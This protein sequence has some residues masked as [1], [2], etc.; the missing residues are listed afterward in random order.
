MSDR[1]VIIIGAGLAGLA[2]GVYAQ[3]AG[4]RAHIFEHA[5]QP[6]GVAAMCFS[7]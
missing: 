1:T 6:G 2:A 4:Y 3:R 5:S 7:R